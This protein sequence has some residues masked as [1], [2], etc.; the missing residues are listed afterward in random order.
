MGGMGAANLEMGFSILE[1]HGMEPET[2]P[3]E[4]PTIDATK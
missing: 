2:I 3:I 1:T 4:I